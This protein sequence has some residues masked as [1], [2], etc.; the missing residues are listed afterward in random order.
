MDPSKFKRRR[1]SAVRDYPIQ[2]HVHPCSCFPVSRKYPPSKIRKGVSV[3][4]DFPVKLDAPAAL[5]NSVSS[6]ASIA[7]NGHDIHACTNDVKESNLSMVVWEERNELDASIAINIHLCTEIRDDK[8]SSVPSIANARDGYECLKSIKED[9]KESCWLPFMMNNVKVD[10][11]A[12]TNIYSYA[13]V[14]RANVLINIG[15]DP[16]EAVVT[17]FDDYQLA[18]K[19]EKSKNL[20]SL[21][22][23]VSSLML[24]E[25]R[26]S[27]SLFGHD[28]QAAFSDDVVSVKT[29]LAEEPRS[30]MVSDERFSDSQEKISLV[31]LS[32]YEVFS[33]NEFRNDRDKVKQI[34]NHF[35]HVYNKLLQVKSGKLRSGL[36]V[37]AA[38]ILQNQHK[39][40]KRNKQF[41]SISGVEIGDYFCW[42]AELNIIGLHCR[43]VHGIDFMKMDGKNLA[44]SVVDSGRYDNVFESNNEEFPDTLVYLGE[45]SNPKVQSKKSIEDQKLRGGN[46][47]L[48]NSVEAK[49]PV[50]VVRKIFF[51]RGKV[52][53]RKYIYD[54]LYFVDSYRQEIASSGKLVF[55]FLLK[56]FPSQPKLDWRK[57][58]RELDCMS[59]NSE[60]NEM[61]PIC[62]VNALDGEK[63]LIND[64][65]SQGKER[66]P[67][68]AV[69]ALDDEKLPIFNYVTSV[70]YPESY[71][72]S[73]INDGCDCIDGCSD[74][75]DCPCIVQNGG[76]TYDY[77]ERL[78]EAKPLIV[79]CGPSCKCFTSCLNRVSQRGIRLP[80]E[81]FK[82][83]AKGWGVR[84]RSFIRRGCFICEYTG[85]ILRDKEG[86]Q[87][88][89]NDEYLFDIAVSN[90]D[91][92][93]RDAHSL[94]SFEGNECFTID[95]ARVGNVGRFINHSC[96]P[97]LFPQS[98]LFDHDNKRM[99][100]IMLFAMEDI[101][102][103]KELTYDY[104]YEKGGVCDA[105]GNIKIKHCY[106]DS[107]DCSGRMY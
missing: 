30:L 2:A 34:I 59:Y 94:G 99:P 21:T 58:V 61:S 15:D 82:A 71:C 32:N 41:G 39:W 52:E 74:S 12:A 43:N 63:P 65:I 101:P 84:S 17:S 95:A 100:H 81:V 85:E 105:N 54:G 68:R 7:T 9:V 51:K 50:R 37:E 6:N 80:L 19:D 76:S 13:G 45:G 4:R 33:N 77:E 64:D 75:E 23:E 83:K 69:N 66:I 16:C 44:I 10:G 31:D 8:P 78:F 93:L 73:M 28:S 36:A 70:T 67:I 22:K 90:G 27:D 1:V 96:S 53:K 86:E 26:C 88:I 98:V 11:P 29:T 104:N 14:E 3:K 48:K 57:L 42:R 24:S 87:R 91:H 97:N 35:R 49:N 107:S 46:L 56:K 89:G 40:I 18:L 62:V 79:E 55:K 102:P 92:S 103:L 20:V 5:R 72:P 106:C 25:E 60:G 47:A 38:I